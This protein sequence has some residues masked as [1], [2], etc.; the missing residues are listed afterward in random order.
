MLAY[1][2]FAVYA[3]HA[4]LTVRFI[5]KLLIPSPIS[6]KHVFLFFHTVCCPI[7]YSGHENK[8]VLGNVSIVFAALLLHPVISVRQAPSGAVQFMS[9]ECHIKKKYP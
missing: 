6:R 2:A 4:Y 7:Y 1:M 9:L 5:F 3:C 8:G